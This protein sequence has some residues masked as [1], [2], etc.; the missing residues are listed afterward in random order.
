M[1]DHGKDEGAR[2][3][4]HIAHDDTDD[5]GTERLPGVHVDYGEEKGRYHDG[6]AGLHLGE[7]AAQDHAAAQ[8]FLKDGGEDGR[9]EEG[10]PERAA[11]HLA[12]QLHNLVIEILHGR[13]RSGGLEIKVVDIVGRHHGGKSKE[14]RD[15]HHLP[16]LER[17]EMAVVELVTRLEEAVFLALLGS[18]HHGGKE[19]E[20]VCHQHGIVRY[21]RLGHKGGKDGYD[22]PPEEITHQEPAQQAEHAAQARYKPGVVGIEVIIVDLTGA[23]C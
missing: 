5:K 12:Q 21:H 3:V 2:L 17:A 15:E 7:E 6:P 1:D 9:E 20:R 13:R 10:T 11:R 16:G 22:Q 18:I 4:I 19:A 14:H 23:K 8:P